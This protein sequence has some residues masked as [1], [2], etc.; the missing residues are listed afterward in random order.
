MYLL[1]IGIVVTYPVKVEIFKQFK[2][3]PLAISATVRYEM[4][5]LKVNLFQ[6]L[7]L[8]A[9]MAIKGISIYPLC[10]N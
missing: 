5:E 10:I 2:I 4:A 8:S 6:S 9:K 7:S 1:F 3:I